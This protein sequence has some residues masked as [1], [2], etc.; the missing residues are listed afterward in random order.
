MAAAAGAHR[1]GHRPPEPDR[2]RVGAAADAGQVGTG[3]WFAHAD[4]EECLGPADAGQVERLLGCRAVFVDQ[5]C[6]LAVRDPV[7]RHRRT[8]AQQF[9]RQPEAREVAARRAA[10]FPRQGQ[11]QPAAFCQ[12][13]AEGRVVSHPGPRALVGLQAVKR[14]GKKG[15]HLGAQGFILGR[16][17]DEF[18][19]AH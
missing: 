13:A 17:G 12:L 3:S 8:R 19:R 2:R 11:A 18:Q 4:A 10:M 9:F 5:R 6:A 16:D 1:R 15:A 14:V 7:G